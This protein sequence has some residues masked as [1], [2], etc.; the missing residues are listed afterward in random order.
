MLYKC[1]WRSRGFP[2]CS[3]SNK[4]IYAWSPRRCFVTTTCAAIFVLPIADGVGGYSLYSRFANEKILSEYWM[5]CVPQCLFLFYLSSCKVFLRWMSCKDGKQLSL[6]L[7]FMGHKMADKK[8]V[9]C[10]TGRRCVLI[11]IFMFIRSKYWNDLRVNK[12]S[13]E[14]IK[15]L[16]FM[17]KFFCW[18]NKNVE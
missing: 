18:I 17:S 11:F 13:R 15:F 10:N 6:S 9:P 1:V 7:S 3:Q 12:S 8:C 16:N 5:K 4:K 2:P 14:F